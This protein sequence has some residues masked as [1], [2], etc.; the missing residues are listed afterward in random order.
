MP[1]LNDTQLILLTT[2][3]QRDNGSLIPFPDSLTAPADRAR[4][5]IGAMIKSG[6]VEEGKVQ[7]AALAWREDGDVN[8]GIR[9]TDA[10]RTALGLTGEPE[11]SSPPPSSE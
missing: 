8:Y 10:G 7:D 11:G 4:K 9:I 5:M 3:S 6:L 1:K 2:A